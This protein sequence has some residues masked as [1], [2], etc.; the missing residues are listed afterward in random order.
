MAEFNSDDHYIYYC[1]QESLRKKWIGPHSKKK[2]KKVQNAILGCNPK[3]YRMISV[4]FQGKP[5][6]IT[7]IQVYAPTPNAKEA[8]VEWFY[9][10]LQDLQELTPEKLSFSSYGTRMQK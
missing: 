7:V 1:G 4:H 10:D 8:E 5:F 2:K 6:N 9:E 3:N